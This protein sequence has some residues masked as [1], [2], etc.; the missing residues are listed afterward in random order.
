MSDTHAHVDSTKYYLP[1]NSPWPILGSVA[2]FCL[3][4]GGAFYLNEWAGGWVLIPGAALLATMFFCWFGTVI[5]EN[6][7]GAFNNAQVDRSFRM[8]MI[9]SSSRR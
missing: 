2:L 6:Q 4:L 7:Q 5:G 1:H 3:M 8:G 9:C